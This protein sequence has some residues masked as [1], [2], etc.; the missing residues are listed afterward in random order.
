MF[1][2]KDTCPECG[3][4]EKGIKSKTCKACSVKRLTA[5]RS[6]PKPE[7]K[8][9]TKP[10]SKPEPKPEPVE[11]VKRVGATTPDGKYYL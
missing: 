7:P 1:N 2:Q 8:P 5:L 10:E 4:N 6:K 11:S 9:E 3:I